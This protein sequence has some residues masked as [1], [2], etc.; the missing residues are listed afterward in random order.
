[1]E[2]KITTTKTYN[3]LNSNNR[4]II[5]RG[6]TRSGKSYSTMQYLI[7]EALSNPNTTISVVRKS[8]PS[9]KKSIWRDFKKIM[10]V[11]NIWNENDY[12]ATEMTYNF[13]NGSIIEFFSVADEQ[14]IRGA[15]R[16]IL[17]CDEANELSYDEFMQL[18]IRTSKK[19]IIVFNPSFLDI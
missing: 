9:L 2:L 12:T 7:V 6:G 13:Y 1:M 10:N 5:L 19:T 11:L 15:S 18:N 4:I 16:N 8:L 17:F 14:R 3:D